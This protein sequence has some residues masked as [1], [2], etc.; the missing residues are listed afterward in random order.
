MKRF[1]FK[2][3]KISGGNVNILFYVYFVQYVNVSYNQAFFLST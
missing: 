2:Q 1:S 3:T